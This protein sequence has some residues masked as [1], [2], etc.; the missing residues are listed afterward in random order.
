[1]TIQPDNSPSRAV[2]E[3]DRTWWRA[4]GKDAGEWL[5]M[6]LGDMKDVRGI[7]INFAD[8]RVD[9]QP[10]TEITGQGMGARQIDGR[11][12]HTRWILEGS[13]DGETYTD[14]KAYTDLGTKQTETFVNELASNVRYIKWIYTNKV[15]GNVALG[16]INLVSTVALS[17]AKA[18][19]TLT[20]AKNLN[21]TDV[22][23][24]EAYIATAV[25]AGSVQMTQVNKVPANT[26]LV[27]K[28]TTPGSEVN[29]PVFDGTDADDVD[30][31]KM[32]GSATETTAVAENGGYILKDGVFQPALAGTLAAGKAYLQ[33]AVSA[34]ILS[35]DF[36][37]EATN[38]ADVISK[39]DNVKGEVYNLNG[40]RVAQPT[41]GLYIVN[42]KKVVLH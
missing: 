42:G 21:F 7:Q 25:A 39:M 14:L 24:L 23:G 12:H 2:E 4:A 34:P 5:M 32:A 41:K 30:G 17:P 26:G 15:D 18:Y 29:V 13:A 3:D 37:N 33:I 10:E 16:N 9:A 19:T 22:T 35:L 31:N 1:M 40:Q 8:D 28:A 38:I 11:T 20:S 27:L 36:G 6:D